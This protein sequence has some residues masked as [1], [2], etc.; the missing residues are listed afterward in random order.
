MDSMKYFLFK[1]NYDTK[2]EI[3]PQP[4]QGTKYKRSQT[5]PKTLSYSFERKN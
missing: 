3:D 1:N 5:N 2:M 4:L